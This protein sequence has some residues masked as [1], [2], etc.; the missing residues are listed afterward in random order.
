MNSKRHTPG[1]VSPRNSQ[2]KTTG[3]TEV[4]F[5]RNAVLEAIRA[6]SR[7][8]HEILVLPQHE[9]ETNELP[10]SVPV[11]VLSKQDM[12]RVS[13][14]ENHQGMAARVSPYRYA[15]LEDLCDLRTIVLLDSVEDPQ[16][17]GSIIRTAYALAGAGIVI[18]EH[19]AAPVTPAA[20]KAS[21]GATEYAKI[22]RVANL[23]AAAQNMKEK[24]FW[25]VGLEADARDHIS[26]VPA[27]D[28]L[29]LVLGGEDTGIRPV[30]TSELD[31]K[32][33]I[34]MEGDFNSLNVSQAAAI[35][36]YELVGRRKP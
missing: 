32:V 27:F 26:S 23:R 28:R 1:F 33:S 30:I 12:N 19:R 21:S 3:N 29:G 16:N 24:G 5:G 7:T 13:G 25:L 9:D 35:A 22:A 36:L 31:L 18:P 15:R 20:V 8:I 2:R 14:T 34:P 6:G 17:L 10:G 4:I 11:R